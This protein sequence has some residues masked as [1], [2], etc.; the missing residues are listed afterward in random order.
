MKLE[1]ETDEDSGTCACTVL[2]SGLEITTA[3]T[4]D[5]RAIIAAGITPQG[6]L[7]KTLTKKELTHDHRGE[8]PGEKERIYEA[9]GKLVDGRVNGGLIPSRTLGDRSHKVHNPGCVIAE[10]AIGHYSLQR[11]DQYL[12][13]ASDGLWDDMSSERVCGVVRKATK[14]Q[15]AAEAL[16][17][18]VAKK[19]GG[20][21]MDDFTCLVIRFLHQK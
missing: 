15:A 3:H 16:A 12:I 8:Y 9:G 17:R 11:E 18:D 20:K 4:G 19:Y 5:C 13:M 2:L 21:H 14:A 6:D 1:A 10:P 7:A